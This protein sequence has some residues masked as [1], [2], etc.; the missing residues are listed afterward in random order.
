MVPYGISI[1]AAGK[2]SRLGTSK[3]LLSL[4]GET[5]VRRAVRTAL[6]TKAGEV[7]VVAGADYPAICQEIRDLRAEV[8]FN[9]DFAL[10][11][12]SS[13]RLAAQSIQPETEILVI[14]LVDQALVTS[15]HLQALVDGIR[16]GRSISASSYGHS[17][18]APCAFHRSEFAR[19][20]TLSG[21]SGAKR[22]LR[23]TPE[24]LAAIDFPDG[25]FD[26]DTLE[27]FEIM[28]KLS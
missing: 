21:D 16:V 10:G 23:E 18:G 11:L 20:L 6:S 24:R 12:S 1:L 27:D 2:S 17:L 7:I 3:A 13:V 5:L 14:S 25:A 15:E 22:L 28:K 4:G 8:F 9:A 19:L 26:V